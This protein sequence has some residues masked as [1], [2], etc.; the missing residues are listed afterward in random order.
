MITS[1][2]DRGVASARYLPCIHLQSYMRERFGSDPGS[3]RSPEE[4][5]ERTLAVP[6]RAARRGRPGLA[7]ALH[8]DALASA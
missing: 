5:S 8:R 6:F 2:G 7:A 3:A 4:M 1:L